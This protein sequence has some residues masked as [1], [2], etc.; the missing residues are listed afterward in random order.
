MVS[1][2][3][4]HQVPPGPCGLW[5]VGSGRA[6]SRRPLPPA[7]TRRLGPGAGMGGGG[8]SRERTPSRAEQGGCSP[9]RKAPQP[10]RLGPSGRAG[11][12]ETPQPEL[13]RAA[14]PASAAGG[15][16]APPP[17]TSP[18]A[19]KPVKRAP[20]PQGPGWGR[21]D[22]PGRRGRR[23]RRGRGNGGGNASCRRP[24]SRSGL[25]GRPRPPTGGATNSETPALRPPR[26]GGNS[27]LGSR[28]RRCRKLP[29]PPSRPP[30]RVCGSDPPPPGRKPPP[31]P[32]GIRGGGRESGGRRPGRQGGWGERKRRRG[33]WG[34]TEAAGLPLH[35]GKWGPARSA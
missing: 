9:E 6:G 18:R 31:R 5:P 22:E 27:R 12:A 13:G 32:A 1:C 26:V 21:G 7:A 25:W 11:L 2:G 34:E 29:G 16:A 20:P 35:V 15:R 30:A 28:P 33:Q 3:W 8:S 23:G 10:A 19:V 17:P 14:I 24:A 4:I